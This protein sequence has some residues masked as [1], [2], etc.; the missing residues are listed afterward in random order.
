ML[1]S[2]E[3]YRLLKDF[4]EHVFNGMVRIDHVGKIVAVLLLLFAADELL[5]TESDVVKAKAIPVSDF[6][7]KLFGDRFAENNRSSEN[8]W[9]QGKVHLSHFV[10]LEAQPTQNDLEIAFQLGRGLLLPANLKAIPIIIPIWLPHEQTV[11]CLAIQVAN[12]KDDRLTPSLKSIFPSMCSHAATEEAILWDKQPKDMVCLFFGF[13]GGELQLHESQFEIWEDMGDINVT[14]IAA[15]GFDTHLFP[16][17]AKW[18]GH[19]DGTD[20]MVMLFKR[21]FGK[22]STINIKGMPWV[23]YTSISERVIMLIFKAI[24]RLDSFDLTGLN[25]TK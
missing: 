10:R 24:G 15:F 12:L 25:S 11:T 2:Q 16:F 14:A 21:L 7:A 1:D 8:V 4:A 18:N 23:L 20:D 5:P 6:F 22:D 9:K 3:R 13:G 19:V 17:F